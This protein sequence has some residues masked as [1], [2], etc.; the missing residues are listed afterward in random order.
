MSKNY[1]VRIAW[2]DVVDKSV[3]MPVGRSTLPA[4]EQPDVA[5]RMGSDDAAEPNAM[6]IPEIVQ[7]P[8]ERKTYAALTSAEK[9][10]PQF[11]ARE[12]VYV[13]RQSFRDTRRAVLKEAKNKKKLAKKRKTVVHSTVE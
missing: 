2:N 5:F 6:V 12:R 9:S 11:F 10:D 4:I 1:E 13:Q 3:E 7:Q 8:I